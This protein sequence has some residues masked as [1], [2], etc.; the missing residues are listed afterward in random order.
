[1]D[2]VLFVMPVLFVIL[3]VYVVKDYIDKNGD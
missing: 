2:Y 3:T 1:M